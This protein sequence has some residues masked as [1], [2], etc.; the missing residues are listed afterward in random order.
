[1]FPA[2]VKRLARFNLSI[3]LIK[4]ASAHGS[5]VPLGERDRVRGNLRRWIA[6]LRFWHMICFYRTVDV[7]QIDVWQ[8]L[9]TDTLTLPFVS[10]RCFK[11]EHWMLVN[12][13]V[14]RVV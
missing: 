4:D 1:M 2:L 8:M 13:S 11:R 3:L 6:K 10:L 7:W 5:L 14:S 12:L 9:H